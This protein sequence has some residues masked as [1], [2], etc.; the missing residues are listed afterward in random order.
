MLANSNDMLFN[1]RKG[2]DMFEDKEYMTLEEAAAAIGIKR[3]SVY[4]YIKKLH[5]QRHTF[6]YNR[7]TWLARA[8]VERIKAIRESPWKVEES[9][10][11]QKISAVKRKAASADYVTAKRRLYAGDEA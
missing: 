2:G 5:I 4:H 1:T 11:T 8:D 6:E 10:A 7:H 3:P 9:E